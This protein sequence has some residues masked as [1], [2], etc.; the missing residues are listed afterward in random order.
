MSLS[1]LYSN[2][3]YY[4]ERAGY[5]QR[6]VNTYSAQITDLSNKISD[7][8]QQLALAR[9]A[10]NSCDDMH[11]VNND[12]KES[13]ESLGMSATAALEID[14]CKAAAQKI[15]DGNDGDIDNAVSACDSLI[16]KL[17]DEISDLKHLYNTAMQN[18]DYRD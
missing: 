9:G 15:V 16:Q 8:E 11:N 14:S 2:L 5:W 18:K 4:N 12:V 3:H 1:S 10:R 13:F 17:Q 6:S 7:R